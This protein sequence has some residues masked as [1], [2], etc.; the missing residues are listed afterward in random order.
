VSDYEVTVYTREGCG[1]CRAT[2]A[3]LGKYGI[4]YNEVD[5]T[6]NSLVVDALIE[7]GHR[8]FPVIE[9]NVIG[10]ESG[11]WSGHRAD[12]LEALKWLIQGDD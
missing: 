12:N 11:S 10:Y 4:R 5:G 7:Q 1:P 3:Y 9:Y 8:E 6:N 2:K